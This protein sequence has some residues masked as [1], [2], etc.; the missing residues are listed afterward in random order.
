MRLI[1][2]LA[3]G[4]AIHTLGV[5]ASAQATAPAGGT[6]LSGSNTTTGPLASLQVHR[7]SVLARMPGRRLEV[8]SSA[9]VPIARCVT[10]CWL[11]LPSGDYTVAWYGPKA[12]ER[13]LNFSVSGPGG[14][15]I[16]EPDEGTASTGLGFGIAGATIA[17]AGA[18]SYVV[19]FSQGCIMSE[20]EEGR[21]T[22][23]AGILLLGGLG[24]MV[25]GGIMAPI[26]FVT[27]SRNRNP[28]LHQSEAGLAV[29]AAPT[30]HG[31]L[32]GLSGRF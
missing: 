10:G 16:E 2:A 27:W 24:A 9:G 11:N 3:L 31:A 29:A 12:E 20:C 25:V 15:E 4:I 28:R 23:T 22:Q 30:S 26:G 13:V 7:F 21:D 14:I 17:A 18:V 5:S 32:L 1:V 6:V 19:G 8:R